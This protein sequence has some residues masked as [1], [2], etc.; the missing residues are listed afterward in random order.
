MFQAKQVMTK[1]VIV[2]KRNANIY[3]A[4]RLMVDNK[5]TGIPVV[6]DDMSLAGMISEKDGLKLLY[7]I[8]DHADSKVEDFMTKGV[9]SFNE[10]DSLV[11]IAECLIKNHFRRVPIL[12]NGKLVGIITRTDI[13]SFIL[14]LR[15]K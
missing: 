9:W 2:V 3:D 8:E 11:D 14:K 15:H 13:I 6:N 12:S 4:I 7:N 1:N 5:I 10:T